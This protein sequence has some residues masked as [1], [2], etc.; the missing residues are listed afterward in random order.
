MRLVGTTIVGV[1]GETGSFQAGIRARITVALEA[2]AATEKVAVV[3]QLFNADFYDVFHTSSQRLGTPPLSL[4]AGQK[5][6]C[7][8]DVDLHLGPGTYYL[9][10]YLYR[11]DTQHEYDHVFPATSFVMTTDRGS[12][13]A[14]NLYP[15]VAR[16]DSR[17]APIAPRVLPTLP[18]T[19]GSPV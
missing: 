8:F 11:Y 13:G 14:A 9:G 12:R 3:I 10:A 6:E 19:D 18:A 5:A 2:L 16:F 15:V 4:S 1:G 7:D 17:A